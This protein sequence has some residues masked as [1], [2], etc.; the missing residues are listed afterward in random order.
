M[1]NYIQKISS[2]EQ[3]SFDEIR[4]IAISEISHFSQNKRDLIYD[5]LKRGTALIETH[6]QLCYYL[7][8]FGPMHQAKM[9]DSL[10]RLPLD[11][12][13]SSFE[14]I[15]W[16]C[17]QA[18]GT[19]NLMDFLSEKNCLQNVKKITLIEPSNTAL[20]RA[21]LHVSAY[22]V[23][24]GNIS[25][26]NRFFEDINA[27]DLNSN[28]GLPVLHIFSNILDVE[29]IDLKHLSKIIDTNVNTINYLL[30][31]G[32]INFG[33][34]RIDAFCNYFNEELIDSIYEFESKSFGPR[35][36]WTYKSKIYKLTPNS[37]GHLIPIEF[38]PPV[39]FQAAY[40]LD[41]IRRARREIGI[42]LSELFS[43]FEVVAPFDLGASVYEDVTPIL[44]VAHNLIVRGLPTKSSLF[45]EEIFRKTFNSSVEEIV[46]G[47]IHFKPT[48]SLDID[49]IK[50]IYSSNSLG[51]SEFSIEL[52]QNTVELL[53]PI[54]IARFQKV[55]LEAIITGHLDIHQSHWNILVQEED[56][57]F[58]AI[59]LKDLQNLIFNLAGL[60]EDFRSFVLPKIELHIISNIAFKNSPLHLNA[61]VH[62]TSNDY[63]KNITFDMVVTLSMLKSIESA[64]DSFSEFKAKNKC[65]FNIRNCSKKR[66]ERVIYTSGLVKYRNLV[67]KSTHG[68]YHEL[69]EPKNHLNY[70]LQLLFRKKE[71][72]PGQLPIL[73]RALQNLPVIGLLPTGGGKSLTYQIAALLQPGVTMVID[74][75]KSL[76]KDQFDGLV[77]S[78]IDCCAYI[79]SSL[80]KIDRENAE[81]KL[82]SSRLLFVFLSPERLS[83][84]RFRDRLKNMHDFNIYFSYGVIDEVHCVSEWGHDF[85]FS[86][87]HL[88]RNLYNFVRSKDTKISLFG[89]TATASFDVLADVERE[90]SGNG[91]FELDSDVIVRYENTNRLELQ[92]K[93]EKVS[94]KFEKDKYYDGKGLMP[95]HLPKA[96]NIG[97]HWPQ[98]DSKGE[99]LLDYLKAL[100]NYFNEL[101]Y[102]ES[103][104]RIKDEY[105]ERQNNDEGTNVD[106]RIEMNNDF[107][108]Q[109]SKYPEAAIVFCPHVDKTG[110]SVK[111][112]ANKIKE[113]LAPETGSFTGQDDDKTS[114]KNL[115]YFRDNKLPI[116]VA[117]KAFGMGIDKPNVRATINMNYSSSLEAFVQEAGRSG[118]DRKLSLATI[119]VSDYRLAKLDYSF[120]HSNPL[121]HVIK[122]KWFH[123]A[124]LHTILIELNIDVPSDKILI[125][126]PE[127][128]IVH[129]H[130]SLDNKMFQYGKCNSACSNFKSCQ[131]KNV[132]SSSRGW[133]SEIELSSELRAQNIN[134]SK[135]HFEFLNADYQSMMYF[136]NSSFKGEM[137]EKIYM[138]KLLNNLGVTVAS[139]EED[140]G[141][142]TDGFLKKLSN[143]NFDE[144]IVI[145]VPYIP[146]DQIP[147]DQSDDT[148][149]NRETDLEK[150]IYRMTCIG[151][152][153]DFTK[154]FANKKFR[155]I[156]KRKNEG[157]YYF[158]L[159]NFLLRYYTPERAD[160]ELAKA[161]AILNIDLTQPEIIQE[162][163][164]CL[165]YLTEF[166]YDKI[167][168]KRKRA[169]DDMRNFCVEGAFESESWLLRNEKLKDFIFFYFNSKYA[170]TDYVTDHG[171]PYSLVV[172]TEEGKVSAPWITEKYIQVAL[173]ENVVG[174]S[175]PLDNIKHLYGAIR[176]ISRSLTDRNPSLE[177]LEAFCLV[178]LGFKKNENLKNQF[179]LRF[180][181]GM[182]EM[183]N[184]INDLDT[185]WAFY[186]DFCSNTKPLLEKEKMTRIMEETTFLIHNSELKNLTEKYLTENE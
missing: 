54:A 103:I 112:N 140:E 144:K 46:Y 28:S 171:E 18:M 149:I 163:Y 104:Q 132:S 154:D 135:K 39:Q 108:K 27:D 14:V 175:T 78:G 29:Q 15:D 44:A 11:L 170:K 64:I 87:L 125:A 176:L 71:F 51:T 32:P 113:E 63:L 136:F 8:A 31:V 22:N 62:Y 152:L 58:A 21:F 26:M 43:H 12:L 45:I 96:I 97:N 131:L 5:E 178:Y 75:L 184:R 100:P 102:D 126:T 105:I 19:L 89:L 91:A 177:L 122:N 38:Y 85:R 141:I 117:T 161:K 72:R 13:N 155:I 37:E 73:D 35:A 151:L 98:Y 92:Y 111:V 146:D 116:M 162:I 4:A 137:T 20:N 61:N 159:R 181:E 165:S 90:L 121:I 186:T 10:K 179:Q 127:N 9:L 128:D 48:Q 65:Y 134:L 23:A 81:N 164:R 34:K 68:I 160:F 86:Y 99:F 17:G 36:N 130:C 167:S 49:G 158:G 174:I 74:P 33:N 145:Y 6:E 109:K 157:G 180:S 42:D 40:E 88:G 41:T 77:N 182:I 183:Y 83:I 2:L 53:S 52:N 153:D 66:S 55:V 110:L 150:A 82:E 106:L 95:K 148:S 169:I 107:F 143:L 3:P 60:T 133:K 139:N 124:D 129:L 173:D 93:I 84:A 168:E 185:F 59:G 114:M 101:Q 115:E 138:N 156:A 172:D 50:N 1:K 16:G 47:E 24:E 76:M 69:I 67:E 120:N 25:K 7:N 30:C 142:L 57:P 147:K 123:E 80:Q 166:V 118:R 70:F 94:V 56:V 119:L 79:N